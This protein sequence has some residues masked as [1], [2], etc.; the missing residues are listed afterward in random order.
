VISPTRAALAGLA[1]VLLAVG[2]HYGGRWA[3]F[4]HHLRAAREALD[5]QDCDEARPH[6][7]A[8]LRLRPDSAEVHFLAARGLRRAGFHD[9]AA[10]HLRECQRLGAPEDDVH[11]EWAMLGAGQGNLPETEPF[12]AQRLAAGAPESGL[13]LEALAQGSIEVY[14]LGRARHYLDLLLQREPDNALGLLWQ[15]WLYETGGRRED[16][17]ENYR[18]AVR[19]HPRQPEVRLR[20]AQVAVRHGDY[21]EA[22]EHLDTL[23]RRG[24][25]RPAVAL[26]LAQLRAGQGDPAKARALLDELL[27]GSPDDGGALVERGK[28]ALQQ[29]EPEEAERDLR[30]AVELAPQDRVALTL[31]SDALYKQG[32]KGEGDEVAARRG[33]IEADMKRL[34]ELYNKMHEAPNDVRLRHEAG[35]ICLRYG[36]DAEAVRWL[37]GAVQLDPSFAPAHESLAE[38]Y[39]RAGRRDLAAHERQ[40]AGRR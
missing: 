28:L 17:L 9:E 37:Q 24:Y 34:E 21:A 11:L 10:D 3:V 5:E 19:A 31:L 7:D 22:E 14:Q 39:D 23:R 2:G 12:L 29:G 30:R 32:K 16:A 40:L 36:Q 26:A 13:I 38:C 27:V 15:G 35:L 8:C 20:L 18:R 33:R 1:L 4:T 25:K 6:L